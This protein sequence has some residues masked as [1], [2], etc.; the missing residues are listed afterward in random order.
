MALTGSS[1]GGGSTAAVVYYEKPSGSVT[2]WSSSNNQTLYTVPAGKYFKGHIIHREYNYPP[3]INNNELFKYIN[4]DENSDSYNN[5]MSHEFRLYAGDI[6]KSG[7]SGSG[8]GGTKV[9]GV[10]FDL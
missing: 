4:I 6:V 1:T 9:Q 8:N 5:Y 2:A 10:E 7:S 3:K